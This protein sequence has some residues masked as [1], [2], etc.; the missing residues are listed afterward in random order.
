M[1]RS[2]H[3]D[4]SV[5]GANCL[6]VRLHLSVSL[7]YVTCMQCIHGR[8]FPL[9][10]TDASKKSKLIPGRGAVQNPVGRFES[11]DLE[12]GEY[13]QEI[14]ADDTDVS[15]SPRTKFYRDHSVSVLTSNDSP[16]VDFNFSVNPY[17]GCEHGCIYCYARPSHEFLGLSAGLDFE[18]KIFVKEKAPELLRK[19]LLAKSWNPQVIS[20]SGVTDCYQPVERRLKITRGCLEVLADFRNP[21]VI[22]TKNHLVTRDIDLIGEMAG[23]RGAKVFLSITSLDTELIA[24]MEPRTSR[25]SMRL[26][27]IRKLAAAGIP[28]GVLIAPVIPALTD[29]EIPAILKAAAEAGSTEAEFTILRLPYGLSD[30][31]AGWLGEHFPDRKEKILKRVRELRGG[32][33]NDAH[34]GSRMRGEGIFADQIRALFRLN[35]RKYGLSERGAELVAEYFRRVEDSNQLSL[36]E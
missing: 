12:R 27:A 6:Y 34:F 8:C 31:F 15:F 11:F 10:E 23:R 33:M 18:T 32:K 13:A 26:D 24:K 2:C 16:D 28:V 9:T 20:L 4:Y 21:F 35:A 19:A 22:I 29:H 3:T 14:P 7:I 17:R 30:L 25:P 5:P 36:F 1:L